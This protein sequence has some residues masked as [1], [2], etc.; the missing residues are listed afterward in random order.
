MGLASS[1]DA[2]FTGSR[3]YSC[4]RSSRRG[5]DLQYAIACTIPC[6]SQISPV[7]AVNGSLCQVVGLQVASG[8]KSSQLGGAG[9][10][11]ALQDGLLC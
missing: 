9:F 3:G 8:G 1:G 7:G 2:S 4:K 11:N 6:D 5:R 10:Y